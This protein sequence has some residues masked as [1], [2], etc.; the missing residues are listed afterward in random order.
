MTERSHDSGTRGPSVAVV[1]GGI[2]A[3]IA[4][5]L[6]GVAGVARV[7]VGPPGGAPTG[8]A[9]ID[10]VGASS[11]GYAVWERLDDGTP[12]RWDPCSPID[13][14]LEPS[15][16]PDRGEDDVVEALA[17]VRD[18]SGL[19]LRLRGTTDERPT[20]NRLPYQPERYGDRW[21]PILIAWA[22]PG[23]AGLPL[24]DVDRGIGMPIAF[25]PSGDRTYVSGQ[26]VLNVDR[27]DLEVGFDDRSGS[28]GAT[29]LHELIHVLGLA[30]VDDPDE[31]MAVYPGTGPVELGPGDLAGLEAIGADGGCRPVP[32]PRP[33]TVADPV[34][35][36]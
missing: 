23:E 12:L 30:H 7:V 20:G 2:L 25:G 28:W 26:I 8:I 24:R 1:V 33:V 3:G 15:G 27:I 5:G 13:L 21:A 16:M 10:P 36:G 32:V 14:V 18:T 34:E 35:P 11:D 6:A 31:L 9:G 29:I 17:R 22:A 19:D 4:L